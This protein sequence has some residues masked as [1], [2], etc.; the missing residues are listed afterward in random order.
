MEPV[1]K[2][3]SV[4]VVGTELAHSKTFGWAKVTG[5]RIQAFAIAMVELVGVDEVKRDGV[6]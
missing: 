3:G 4:L 2:L 5:G 1:V 6:P